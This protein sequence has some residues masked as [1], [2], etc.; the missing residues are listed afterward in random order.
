MANFTMGVRHANTEPRDDLLIEHGHLRVPQQIEE[1]YMTDTSGSEIELGSAKTSSLDKLV[2]YPLAR[3]EPL[4]TATAA[5]ARDSHPATPC[6]LCRA[7][8]SDFA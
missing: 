6:R 4:T 5:L 1:R 2:H 8:K 7:C 3:Q